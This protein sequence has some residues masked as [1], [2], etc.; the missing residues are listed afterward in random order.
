MFARLVRP[1]PALLFC[2]TVITVSPALAQES[3]TTVEKVAERDGEKADGK[4]K[5]ETKTE[6][7]ADGAAET[8]P[9]LQG[10]GEVDQGAI[11]P[12]IS[13]PSGLFRL[14]T[15]D[16]GKRHSL[17]LAYHLEF[18]RAGDF[19][20]KPDTHTRFIGTL[21]AS[22]TPWRYLEFFANL[23]SQANSNE[24]NDPNRQ[25]PEVILAMGDFA[26]GG[27]FQYP[28]APYFS[29]G[30]N[31]ELKFFNSVGGV[32]IEGKATSAYLGTLLSFD[33]EPLVSVPLRFHLNAG[34]M[35]DNTNEL[36]EFTNY[37]L[38]SLQVEKFA[39]GIQPS[40][41]QI[42]FGIDLSL[43]RWVGFGLSPIIEANVDIATGEPDPDF[44]HPR[45]VGNNRPLSPADIDGRATAWLTVGVRANPV[46]GL[47]TELGF[48]IGI[49]S[50]GYGHGP[51]VA[52][53]NMIFSVGYAYDVTATG[54]MVKAEPVIKTVVKEVPPQV[55]KI[56]GRITNA[57]TAEPVE[58]A[59]VTFPGKDMTGL[60]SDPDGSFLS[61]GFPEGEL[62]VVVRHPDF[63]PARVKTTIKAGQETRIE[64]PLMPA[65]PKVSKISGQVVNA[66]GSPVSSTINITGTESR[67]ITTGAGGAFELPL[68]PGN[69]TVVAEATGYFRK[70]QQVALTGGASAP[71]QFKLSARPKRSLVQVTKNQIVIKRKVHFATGTANLMPDSM[72]LLDSIV[73][74][75]ASNP[76]ITLVEVQGHTDNRG[77]AASNMRLSQARASAVMDYLVRGGIAD[78]R[79]R[80]RGYGPTKPKAPNITPGMRAKNR[81]VEF[82][83]VGR[84]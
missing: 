80:A 49:Q 46:R 73:D 61:Y 26:F 33:L 40:R 57:K 45:F 31:F 10:S 9:P 21:A 32:S 59:I 64:V 70:A 82:V 78:S 28:L 52:P 63:R 39:L 65:P 38:A 12:T 20:V 42:K 29:L 3:T 69:Y 58:G 68:K 77:S 56:R 1:L 79:L 11:A 43:R 84:K 66:A 4:N 8:K 6:A 36:S 47:M 76:G 81:R 5:A 54:T 75:L 62:T 14:V 35:I 2:A 72:Q 37:S 24:R 71:L 53:W 23:K 27:K 44:N 19:L 30:A 67:T 18:F 15:S 74:V 41:F 60:S 51:P 7:K 83:I 22:Y 50:P 16:I 17:R 48:D 13:G 25:D 34:M 55:G